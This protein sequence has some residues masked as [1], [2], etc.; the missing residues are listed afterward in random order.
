MITPRATRL[1]RAAD[2]RKYRDALVA[3]ACDGHPGDGVLAVRDRLLVLPTRAAAAHLTRTIEQ[4][5]VT[6]SAAVLLPDMCTSAEL[7]VRLAARLPPDAPLLTDAER[8]VLLGVACREVRDAGVEP[9][10]RLR[11]ALV[12]EILRFYDTLRGFQKDVDTFERLALGALEP[13]AA[14]DRGAERLVRQTRF[15]VAAFREFERRSVDA[16]ADIHALRARLRSEAPARPVRHVV[17]AVGD[18]TFDRHGL[19]AAD[20]DLLTRLPGLE[21]LDVVVTDRTLAGGPH[22]RWH[23]LLPAIEEVRF[24]DDDPGD[25]GRVSSPSAVAQGIPRRVEG[26]SEP[27][28]GPILLVPTED[29]HAHVARDREE[30]VVGFARRIK[31]AARRQEVAPSRVALVVRQ[32]LPYVYVAREVLRS[33]GVP[34]QTFDTL[35]LAAEPYAAALDLVFAAVSAGFARGP[36]TALL[37]SPHFVFRDAAGA[38]ISARDVNALDRALSEAGYPGEI[39]ALDRLLQQWR[40]SNARLRLPGEALRAVIAELAPL[41]SAMPAHSH[42][43][44]L[45][46]FIAA[47]S[48]TRPSEA[49]SEQVPSTRA[50]AGSVQVLDEDLLARERRAR[51]AVLATLESLHRA[52]A[53]FDQA[54]VDFDDVAATVRRWL[55]AQTFA[56]RAGAT[57]VHIV[58]AASARFGE[59]DDVQ[60]AGVVEGEW[61][62]PPRRNIF[63]SPALLRDLGWPSEA[64]RLDGIRTAFAD[65]LRL[66]AKHLVVSAFSLEA[67]ALVSPSALLDELEAA[68]LPT[69]TVASPAVRIF[70]DEALAL[71]PCDVRALP[72]ATAAWAGQRRQAG[73]PQDPR[74]HG[75]ITSQPAAPWSVSA[76][77][78]YQDCPFRFFAGDVLRLQEGPEDETA[79]S[80]RARG[81]FIHEVFQRF[82]EAWDA[83]GKGTITVD[84]LDDAHELFTRVAE[85][86]LARVPESDAALERTRLFGSAISIGLVDVVLGLEASRPV[87]VRERLLEYRLDGVFTLGDATRRV[88]L[89]GVADRIDLIDGRRLRVIDYKSGSAPNPK[90]ALQ[91]A[92]Y[93]LCALERL[94]ARDVPAGLPAVAAAQAGALAEARA[95][96]KT[97]LPWAVDEAAYVVFTG[98]RPLVSIVKPGAAAPAALPAARRRVFEAVAGI[99]RGEF[100]PRPHDPLICRSC[101]YSSVCRKD[102]VGD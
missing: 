28:A 98:R 34:S 82:F 77:E 37:R 89:K 55:E 18:D 51:G 22:E 72:P 85:P 23:Q 48:S 36:A 79:L 75:F 49:R 93:A 81:R 60:L 3:L 90:R 65:L 33:A 68:G 58:D 87:D 97:G 63:Y 94:S 64:E 44:V 84:R 91:V 57:G 66:P 19:V 54:P 50:D 46:A 62:E 17:I 2:L 39:E 47:H 78:R 7:P 20:W 6:P 4:R 69:R 35:P 41:R 27:G 96:A 9:P 38:A 11:A 13:G 45:R 92:V 88:A 29:V 5:L 12:A 14:Y 73:D 43:S 67:D 70:E 16:G 53:R 74:F 99:E 21:R 42:L 80:P 83:G 59:F 15:L 71:D 26:R 52:C 76:L 31:R 100:P 8:E 102:Y 25:A 95:L 10:F 86:L 101:A 30:E 24:G 1:V 61:P 32:P 56:P 40:E